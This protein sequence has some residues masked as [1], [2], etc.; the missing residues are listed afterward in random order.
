MVRK[1]VTVTLVNRWLE[2]RRSARATFGVR[3][4]RRSRV[5][6][7]VNNVP[8]GCARFRSDCFRK[9]LRRFNKEGGRGSAVARVTKIRQEA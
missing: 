8:A 4:K 1:A 7:L 2:L 9:F 5:A 6:G 3:K